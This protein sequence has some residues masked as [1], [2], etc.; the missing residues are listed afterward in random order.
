VGFLYFLL[1]L[2]VGLA[3]LAQWQRRYNQRLVAHLQLL[4]VGP[5][6]ISPLARINSAILAQQQITDDLEQQLQLWQQILYSAPIAYLQVDQDNQ[7]SWSNQQA[8]Q[9]LEI[10]PRYTDPTDRWLLLQVV[11]SY[12]LDRLVQKTRKQQQLY[13][14]EWSHHLTSIQGAGASRKLP[15]R[16]HGLPLPQGQVGIFL[17]DRREATALEEERD[18]WASDVSHEL[19]TPLTSIRLVAETLQSRVEPGLRTWADRLLN[20]TIRLS[21]LVQD[22]L[23]LGRITL[24]PS[25]LS[26]A[27][28]V[29]LPQLVQAAWLTLE[30]LS[31]QKRIKLSATELDPM[32]VRGDAAQLYRV[33]LNVFDNAIKYSPIDSKIT[34]KI[35]CFEAALN[36]NPSVQLDIIDE[37]IGFSAE[38][39]PRVFER[40]YRADPARSR[41]STLGGAAP[42]VGSGGGLG[43]AIVQQIVEAHGGY[44][45]ASNHPQ[46]GGAWLQIFLPLANTVSIQSPL[47]SIRS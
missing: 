42:I 8:C 23:D 34:V 17:E 25:N 11:R 21:T 46:T 26:N 35:H 37:G 22:L 12:E 9:L 41:P 10:N 28:L 29:N 13:Q 1:G 18:R 39:L 3:G 38:D 2:A 5:A 7:L 4:P 15:L 19:K 40:F 27:A 16:G 6:Q 30:P 24:T 31:S 36:A 33:I 32:E 45:Q 47:P 43:L 14:Q 44:V 20:E